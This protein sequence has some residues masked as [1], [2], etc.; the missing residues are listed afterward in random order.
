MFNFNSVVDQVTKAS[1]SPLMYV[2]D[3]AIR[4]NLETL[5]EA[6]A[7][8]VK[9]VYDTNLELA[10]QVTEVAKSFDFKS[11]DFTKSFTGTTKSS[12]KETA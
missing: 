3:K 11:F 8:F 10:K 2:E 4:A 6:Q 7:D 9:T 5:V 1:K 12:K